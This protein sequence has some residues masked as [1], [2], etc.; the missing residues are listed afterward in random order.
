M[1][2]TDIDRLNEFVLTRLSRFLNETPDAIT[3]DMM[4]EMTDGLGLSPAEAYAQLLCASCGLDAAG[5]AFDRAICRDYFLPMVR[6]LDADEF[7]R[8][9][10]YRTVRIPEARLGRWE[11]RAERCRPF[12]AFVCGDMRRLP[13]GRVLPQIGFFDREFTYP[14]VLE[15]GREWM[16]ITPN[17]IETM[18]PAVQAARGRVLAYGLGLGY[19]ARLALE[20][21]EVTDVT[22]VE[23]DPEVIALFEAHIRPQFPRGEALRIVQD[24]AFRFAAAE[25]GK[26]SSDVVFTDLWH[27][28]SDGLELWQRMRSL[29]K[30]SPG[31][32]FVYW[33]EDTLRC[34]LPEA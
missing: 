11:F 32:R 16:L 21:P 12:E 18:R 6:A 26:G 8:D 28:P 31:S 30:H 15:D 29:E 19:F 1:H 34:Y 27:D 23:R 10:Y 13:D 24:D 5:S 33:I 20:K 9:V 17:E 2:D 4:V 14:A 25:M 7:A 22:V 3:A